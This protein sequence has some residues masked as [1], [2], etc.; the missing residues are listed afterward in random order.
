M[1]RV[2]VKDKAWGK[3]LSSPIKAL[4][5]QCFLHLCRTFEDPDITFTLE[6]EVDPE[7][8]T[9]SMKSSD[10][11]I[12]EQ[13]WQGVYEDITKKYERGEKKLKAEYEILSRLRVSLVDE[14]RHYSGLVTGTG[15]D[16]EV[17]NNLFITAKPSVYLVNLSEKDFIRKKNK[18][19][20]KIKEYVDKMILEQWSFLSQAPLSKSLQK[21]RPTKKEKLQDEN[22]CF[23]NSREDYC[24]GYKL[25]ALNTSHLVQMKSRLGLF[26]GRRRHRPL[27]GSS[28][29][30]EKGSLW[31][32]L[33]VCWLLKELGTEAAVKAAG[34]YR[35]QGRIIR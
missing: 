13:F 8:L 29:D 17:L 31:L 23:T 25:L 22:K 10:S 27:V 4:W 14:K 30:F 6:G 26:K 1:V 11:R 9:S 18:W 2:Q 12:Q 33:W 35:Q 15:A 5:C 16:I 24:T 3:M 32:T 20:P 7:I 21:W 28:T 19:L 34:K